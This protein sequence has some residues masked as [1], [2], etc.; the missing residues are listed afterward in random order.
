M[1]P[2]F[3]VI[4]PNFN[5]GTTLRRAIASVLA[6]RHLA[7]EIIVVDDGSTDNSEAVAAS[8][9]DRIRYL[10]QTNQGVSAARNHGVA[11]A[12]SDWIAFLDA[13][14]EYHPDRLLAHAEWIRDEPDVDFLLADQE[15]RDADGNFLN[16]FMERTRSGQALFR[17]YPDAERIPLREED[18]GLLIDDGFAEIRTISLRRE[19]FMEL[20]GF[21]LGHRIGEDAHLLI[22][23]FAGSR[24]G[25]VV[26]KILATYYIY[27]G[28][29]LRRDPRQS[30]QLFVETLDALSVAL[31]DAPRSIRAGLAQKSRHTRLSL[32]YA[33]LRAGHRWQAIRSVMPNL[34]RT[35]SLA[36]LKDVVSV[37]RGLVS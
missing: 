34:L 32:A 28:S 35:P 26:P 10:R 20:G 8:F 24:K 29:A 21:P 16:V 5:N 27:P 22:R 6:Q 4:I 15:A 18:F 1:C 11:A 37:A 33:H 36:T 7:H 12:T 19:R 25:G 31:K 30:M 13:D 3:A 14:D 2:S 23:L 17:K 9:G